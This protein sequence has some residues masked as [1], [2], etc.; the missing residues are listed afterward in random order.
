MYGGFLLFSWFLPRSIQICLVNILYIFMRIVYVYVV[1]NT[2]A[3][4]VTWVK[5]ISHSEAFV[6]LTFPFINYDIYF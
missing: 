4:S 6:L 5:E 3:F 2:N 1:T